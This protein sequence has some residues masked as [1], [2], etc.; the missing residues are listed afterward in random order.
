M[1]QWCP[2][3]FGVAEDCPCIFD[4]VWMN[5]SSVTKL[6]ASMHPLQQFGPRGSVD[7]TCDCSQWCDSITDQ[8]LQLLI[9]RQNVM[10]HH[11]D[12]HD[13]SWLER[14]WDGWNIMLITTKFHVLFLIITM[15]FSFFFCC[16]CSRDKEVCIVWCVIHSLGWLR[17]FKWLVI[18]VHKRSTLWHPQDTHEERQPASKAEGW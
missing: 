3:N 5:I 14:C 17:V 7:F 1:F 4:T 13:Q 11:H 12:N 15:L 6:N 2:G 10:L 18:E 8:I 9:F 16:C